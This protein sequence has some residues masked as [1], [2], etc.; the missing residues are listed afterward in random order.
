MATE[1]NTTEFLKQ[2]AAGYRASVNQLREQGMAMEQQL[3]KIKA[4]ILMHSGAAQAIEDII[5][6]CVNK[7][8]P[9]TQTGAAEKQ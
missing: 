5:K 1:K 7:P 6:Q 4:D 9:A 8:E 2:Q 3:A